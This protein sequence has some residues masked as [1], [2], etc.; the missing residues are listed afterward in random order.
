VG[1]IKR[2]TPHFGKEKVPGISFDDC[3]RRKTRAIKEES[4]G[5]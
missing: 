2:E 5:D 4:T 3:V 1:L